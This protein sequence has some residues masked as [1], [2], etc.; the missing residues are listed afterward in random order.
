[1]DAKEPKKSLGPRWLHLS[2]KS[3][4][5]ALVSNWREAEAHACLLCPSF[6]PFGPRGTWVAMGNGAMGRQRKQGLPS[7]F[8]MHQ[9]SQHLR[10]SFHDN[11][12]RLFS[13]TR[14]RDSITLLSQRIL[15]PGWSLLS[16][17]LFPTKVNCKTSERGTSFASFHRTTQ[18]REHL[19]ISFAKLDPHLQISIEIAN[20]VNTH[21][22][23]CLV[24]V[25]LTGAGTSKP[26]SALDHNP[27]LG[28]S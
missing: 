21:L 12:C 28:S 16:S 15:L 13:G 27:L 23:T 5:G 10:P 24:P 7:L 9:R 25:A 3:N 17:P 1:M 11:I 20:T 4:E 2:P 14:I 18:S 6:S 22:L 26:I 8:L 19:L